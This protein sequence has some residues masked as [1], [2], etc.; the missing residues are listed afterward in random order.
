[1]LSSA[2]GTEGHCAS[3]RR[4]RGNGACRTPTRAR[5]AVPARAA[6]GMARGSSRPA[7]PRD[8]GTPHLSPTGPCANLGFAPAQWAAQGPTPLGLHPGERVLPGPSTPALCN[9]VSAGARAPLLRWG[10]VGGNPFS[11]HY[12]RTRPFFLQAPPPL[13]WLC[14]GEC[15]GQTSDVAAASASP[16]P[17]P[18]TGPSALTATGSARRVATLSMVSPAF[19]RPNDGELAA[20]ERAF[21]ACPRLSS[22]Q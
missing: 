16:R 3:G 4:G 8:S 12:D 20:S 13:P 11:R 21:R 2:P 15:G 10:P 6:A 17:A 19:T 7:L 9:S 1:M 14:P 18:P 5:C 22:T